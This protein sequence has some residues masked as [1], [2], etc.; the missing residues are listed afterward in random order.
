MGLKRYSNP[1]SALAQMRWRKTTPAKRAGIMAKVAA[2]RMSKMTPH[3]RKVVAQKGGRAS[4]RAR[5]GAKG[6][7]YVG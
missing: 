1:A 4:V 3:D 7:K 5:F 2:G 6:L